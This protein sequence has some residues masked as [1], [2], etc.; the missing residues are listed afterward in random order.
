MFE[1]WESRDGGGV[2]LEGSGSCLGPCSS[3]ILAAVWIGV[4]YESRFSLIS[5]TSYHVRA[6]RLRVIPPSTPPP[7]HKKKKKK[8]NCHGK[9]FLLKL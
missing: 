1:G 4:S 2:G 5:S 6:G 9:P 8:K 7:P 3:S